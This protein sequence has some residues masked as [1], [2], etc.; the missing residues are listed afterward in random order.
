MDL[1]CSAVVV[2]SVIAVEE[3]EGLQKKARTATVRFPPQL[4]KHLSNFIGLIFNFF[5]VKLDRQ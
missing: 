1:Y 3:R 5:C 4:L 2:F